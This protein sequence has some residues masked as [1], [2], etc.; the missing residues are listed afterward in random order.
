ML[1]AVLDTNV[2]VSSLLNKT[3]APARLLDAWRAG[4]YLL[5]I[6]P[7]II[8]EIKSVLELPRIRKRYAL[9]GQEIRQLLDLLEKDAILAPG[10]SPTKG[11]VPQDPADEMFLSC[12]LEAGADFIVSGDN[13]LLNL[14]SYRKIPIITV[15][16]FLDHLS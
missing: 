8:A 6:S 3:G 9:T 13:H 1:R 7:P 11:A 14:K 5:V 2:F 10:L 12:A 15:Q 16:E 4:E